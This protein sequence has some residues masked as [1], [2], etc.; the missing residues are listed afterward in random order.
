MIW[1]EF[2][3]EDMSVFPEAISVPESGVASMWILSHDLRL[4]VH[5]TRIREGVKGYFMEGRRRVAEA[6]I[7]RI[8]G[9]HENADKS[10]K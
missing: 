6:V 8:L 3:N 4:Q 7:T 5:R 10:R 9:L 2:L 1:P